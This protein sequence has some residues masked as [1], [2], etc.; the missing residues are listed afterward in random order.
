MCLWRRYNVHARVM[1]CFVCHQYIK[2]KIRNTVSR[3][4]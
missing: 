1:S 2:D 3:Q 4:K